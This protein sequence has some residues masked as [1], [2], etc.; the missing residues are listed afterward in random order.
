MKDNDK[1]LYI[2]SDEEFSKYFVY[3]SD[4]PGARE[5]AEAE[6]DKHP[7]LPY[8]EVDGVIIPNRRQY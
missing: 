7:D 4:I 6:F 8:I 2:M 3:E 5:K 1:G